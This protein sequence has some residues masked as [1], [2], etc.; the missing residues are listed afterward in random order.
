MKSNFDIEY[1]GNKWYIWAELPATDVWCFSADESNAW[2]VPPFLGLFLS[3]QDLG[4]Y[5]FL[6]T[7]L[8]SIPLYGILSGEVALHGDKNTTA[9]TPDDLRLSPSMIEMLTSQAAGMMPPGTSAMFA[10]VENIKFHQF[11]EQVNSSRVYTEAL[12]QTISTSGLTGLQSTSEK[13]TVSMVNASKSIE[14]RFADI[15]YPQFIKFVNTIFDKRLGLK[16]Q[17]K[18]E[19]F[20]DVFTEKD[21]VTD[22]QKQ[23][24]AGQSYLMPRMLACY[25][26]DMNAADSI[27]EWIDASNIYKKMDV[28]PNINTQS[29]D[30]GGSTITKG[31]RPELSEEKIDN[32]HTGS[33]VDLGI[34]KGEDHTFTISNISG[35]E[36]ERVMSLIEE[37]GYDIQM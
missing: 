5:Q 18:F 30:I 23:I 13:P 22:L 20:G 26:L 19:M 24:Y 17:W 7:Q 34:N 35:D 8:V 12:Q 25:S 3:F 11:Q 33:N 27:L 21:V 29:S 28:P 32:E 1:S 36:A 10:P 4:S 15:L 2:Q 16:Y 37:A 6:Q 14:K 9:Q 31:G